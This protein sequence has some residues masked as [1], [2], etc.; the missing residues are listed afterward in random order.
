MVARELD[1]LVEGIHAPFP[2]CEGKREV[3]PGKWKYVRIEFEFESRNYCSHRDNQKLDACDLIVSWRDNWPDC[4]P[5]LEGIELS[6]K[7]QLLHNI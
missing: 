4:P 7:I 3:S 2:A 6:S 1:F 5:N